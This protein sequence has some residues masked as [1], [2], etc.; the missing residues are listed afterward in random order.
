ML[1]SRKITGVALL[2]ICTLSWSLASCQSSSGS[3]A[4]ANP[5]FPPILTPMV[6]PATSTPNNTPAPKP[7]NTPQTRPAA[8]TV[9]TG[10]YNECPPEGMGPFGPLQAQESGCNCPPMG[11]QPA[12][13]DLRITNISAAPVDWTATAD[14]T[15]GGSVSPSNG[16]LQ[17]GAVVELNLSTPGGPSDKNQL[18]N[19]QLSWSA[20]PNDNSGLYVSACWNAY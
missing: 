4:K 12:W 16:T 8:T 6:T 10:N 18:F 15:A 2:T 14:Y 19:V 13:E 20:N 7:T 5:T 1:A 17:P 11:G 9:P 3:V